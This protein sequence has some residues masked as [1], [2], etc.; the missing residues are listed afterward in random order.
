MEASQF[1]TA[2]A[3]LTELLLEIWLKNEMNPTQAQS[4]FFKIILGRFR[5][6]LR[7]LENGAWTLDKECPW[8]VCVKSFALLIT[9]Q[10]LHAAGKSSLL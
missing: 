10:F 5:H 9:G 8:A 7:E 3:I 6:V 4:K 2:A 1:N